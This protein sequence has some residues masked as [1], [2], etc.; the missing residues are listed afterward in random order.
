MPVDGAS[1]F[2][3]QVTMA[4]F[5]TIAVERDKLAAALKRFAD[6]GAIIV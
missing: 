2:A 3:A 5:A 4:I 1:A 6:R